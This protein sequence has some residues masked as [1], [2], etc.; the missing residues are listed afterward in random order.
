MGCPVKMADIWH[1]QLWLRE[2]AFSP[3]SSF[4]TKEL[5]RATAASLPVD[6]TKEKHLHSS[7]AFFM[8]NFMAWPTPALCS[9]FP[10]GESKARAQNEKDLGQ[11][12]HENQRNEKG[13]SSPNTKQKFPS[14]FSFYTTD[15]DQEKK[16][17]C[18]HTRS[19]IFETNS[20]M[21]RTSISSNLMYR[22]YYILCIIK[23]E[24]PPLAKVM[25]LFSFITTLLTLCSI[26][27]YMLMA[28]FWRQMALCEY[29]IVWKLLLPGLWINHC[30][31]FWA[32]FLSCGD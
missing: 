7:S 6:L 4:W 27:D 19:F 24:L 11:T 16:S 9:P 17:L 12:S 5:P 2:T 25:C 8:C 1:N 22:V 28:G 23:V 14:I 21:T 10:T 31:R 15:F 20:G 29:V 18:T 32:L 13:G 26:I 30:F 3:W